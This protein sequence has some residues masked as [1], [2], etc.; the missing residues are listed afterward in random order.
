MIDCR[1][2]W[3]I[4]VWDIHVKGDESP[5]V[6]MYGHSMAGAA[7]GILT[8]NGKRVDGADPPCLGFDGGYILPNAQPVLLYT[9]KAG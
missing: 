9:A 2:I 5:L 6:L 4:V 8:G 7:L 3:Y 1:V